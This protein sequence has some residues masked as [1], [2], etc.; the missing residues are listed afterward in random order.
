MGQIEADEI[1]HVK[2]LDCTSVVIH[3]LEHH[4]GGST[5][6]LGS[7]PIL[8]RTRWGGQGP[9]TSLPIHQPH[10]SRFIHWALG[11]YAQKGPGKLDLIRFSGYI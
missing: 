1:P 7:K 11:V 3:S 8:W 2:G 4:T 9:P 6:W 10:Q 5:F